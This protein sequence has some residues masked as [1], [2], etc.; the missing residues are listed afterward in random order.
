[1]SLVLNYC[2]KLDNFLNFDPIA[3][4]WHCCCLIAITFIFFSAS[5]LIFISTMCN[6]FTMIDD[7]D[8]THP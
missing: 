5:V 1:M 7:I 8:I 2:L 6:E 3:Q 4:L